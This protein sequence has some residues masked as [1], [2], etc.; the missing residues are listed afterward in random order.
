VPCS[1]TSATRQVFGS[2]ET[3]TA[4]C[5]PRRFCLAPYGWG[6][7]IRLSQIILAGCVPV[8]IQ[9][10]IYQPLEDVLN[11]NDFSLRLPRCVAPRAAT[12][13]RLCPQL[14]ATGVHTPVAC[15]LS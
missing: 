8:I 3:R 1:L 5:S 6:W 2:A 14:L 9:P 13:V 11:Y 4:C 12:A 7:G 10:H 15:S